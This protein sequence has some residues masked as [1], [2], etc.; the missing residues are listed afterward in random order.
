MGCEHMQLLRA[1][2][3]LVISCVLVFK[4]YE[5]AG[6]FHRP[7]LPIANKHLAATKLT[8][9]V[10]EMF[11]GSLSRKTDCREIERHR[12]YST[13]HYGYAMPA[14]RKTNK[15]ESIESWKESPNE[16]IIIA[17]HKRLCCDCSNRLRQIST[18]YS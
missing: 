4:A 5:T 1:V 9:V 11:V 3:E 18:R 6:K 8:E 14:D 16:T 12:E 7:E 2:I 13:L 17:R 10:R 15:L